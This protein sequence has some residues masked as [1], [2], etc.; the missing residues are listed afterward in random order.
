M[1]HLCCISFP[2]PH[3]FP[4]RCASKI[5]ALHTDA[6]VRSS[7]GPTSPIASWLA[8]SKSGSLLRYLANKTNIS[9]AKPPTGGSARQ[10]QSARLLSLHPSGQPCDISLG[11]HRA[12]VPGQSEQQHPYT[13]PVVPTAPREGAPPA[14]GIC[15]KVCASVGSCTQNV[16]LHLVHGSVHSAWFDSQC[17]VLCPVHGVAFDAWFCAWGMVLF[18]VHGAV[19]SAW[20]CSRC[21]V[22][23]LVHGSV[24]GA[25]FCSKCMALW[26]VH[27]AAPNAWCCAQCVVLR[28]MHGAAHDAWCCGWC[29]VLCPVH[30]AAELATARKR[31]EQGEARQRAS[32]VRSGQTNAGDSACSRFPSRAQ[33]SPAGAQIWGWGCTAQQM[34]TRSPC[35]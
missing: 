2:C 13:G 35:S 16:V 23:R 34:G 14:L 4:A 28:P 6:A 9:L 7:N 1:C 25:W 21:T 27:G 32:I 19:P 17:M 26:P 12:L 11:M 33:H 3:L 18:L 20:C 31:G 22:L 15:A 10:Q 30:G 29:K 24:H 8:A 5:T